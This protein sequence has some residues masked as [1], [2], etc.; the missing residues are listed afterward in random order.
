MATDRSATSRPSERSAPSTRSDRWAGSLATQ[1]CCPPRWGRLARLKKREPP[2]GSPVG[3]QAWGRPAPAPGV[4]C[5]SRGAERGL[6]VL[7]AAQEQPHCGPDSAG[8]LDTSRHSFRW[9]G[10]LK[11]RS[12]LKPLFRGND[13]TRKVSEN[14]AYRPCWW[15]F[16]TR[17]SV[18]RGGIRDETYGCDRSRMSALASVTCP[19]SNYVE[20]TDA[21]RCIRLAKRAVR[22]L[23]KRSQ[24]QSRW[25]DSK[26]ISPQNA[27]S[28]LF[29]CPTTVTADLGST[30]HR[31]GLA[32][33]EF[34]CAQSEARV[35]SDHRAGVEHHDFDAG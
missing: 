24:S 35:E 23:P 19:H 11:E 25:N 5:Q 15:S 16:N 18:S 27:G 34:G 6:R 14:R 1:P 17:R 10:V 7:T 33:V 8:R 2:P 21:R 29:A 13:S 4:Q 32:A 9:R 22:P 3:R 30:P 28:A 26:V 20:E 31:I 12:H